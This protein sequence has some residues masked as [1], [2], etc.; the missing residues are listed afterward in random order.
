[1]FICSVIS[2]GNIK[3]NHFHLLHISLVASLPKKTFNL[4]S[5]Q[6]KKQPFF[7]FGNKRHKSEISRIIV[8]SSVNVLYNYHL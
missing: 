5:S 6:I 8:I 4:N 3:S 7:L 1:M 2:C